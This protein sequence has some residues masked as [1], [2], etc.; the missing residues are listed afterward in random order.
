[1]RSPVRRLAIETSLGALRIL[2]AVQVLAAVGLAVAPLVLPQRQWRFTV[3][4]RWLGVALLASIGV[5][6]VVRRWSQADT[7]S[8][9]DTAHRLDTHRLGATDVMLVVALPIYVLALANGRI[10]TSGDN[11]ATR[12]LGMVLVREHTIDLSRLPEYQGEPLHYS[13]LRVGNR[14]LPVYP[15][16]TALVSVPYVA[17]ALAIRDPG[18][19]LPPRLVN[20]WEKHLSALL[21]AT[22]TAALFLALRR[23][24]GEPAAL[25]A[26]F[27]FA[28]ATTAFSSM[29]QALWSTTGEVLFLCLALW[30]VLPDEGGAARSLGAGLLLGAAFLCRP[31]AL[32]AAAAIGLGL[33]ARGRRGTGWYALGVT[34]STVAVVTVLYALY[35]HPLGAYG[36]MHRTTWGHNVAEGLLGT[37]LSPSRGLLVF[38]PYLLLCLIAWPGRSAIPALRPWL[39]AATFA[40]AMNYIVVSVF[41]HWHGGWSIGPRL[42]TEATPFLAVLTVPAWLQLAHRPWLR[43]PFLLAVAFAAGT[44]LLCVYTERAERANLVLTD[45]A[46]FWSLR[47]SQI[48]ALWCPSHSVV[49]AQPFEA[50]EED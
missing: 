11:A 43:A 1:M 22:A 34:V 24:A 41:D 48:V 39:L 25:G 8:T 10:H 6:A 9:V 21:A 45:T 13:A 3:E 50:S 42:L 4:H 36:L 27:V 14:V 16:G 17:A 15:I 31:T 32:A 23:I 29:S 46:A 33:V 30:L 5:M 26:A 20:R 47:Q 2:R 28:F 7:P 12:L 38:C 19:V 40:V 18:P 49:D 37:L 44:Q 35:G